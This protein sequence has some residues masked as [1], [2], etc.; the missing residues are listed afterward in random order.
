M[1]YRVFG[2]SPTEPAPAGLLGHLHQLGVAVGANFSGDQD[3][4]FRADLVLEPAGDTV[5]LERY[6]VSEEGIRGELN[7]WAAWVEATGDGLVQERLMRHL[8]G[9]K[10]L[11]TVRPPDVVAGAE[12]VGNLCLDVCRFLA[13]ETEGIYQVDDQGFFEPD[14]RPL[15]KE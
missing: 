13:R 5:L 8:I 1:W 2:T 6:L 3:G 4:W 10:Q 9:T 15:L 12:R 11:F 14:G 7:N